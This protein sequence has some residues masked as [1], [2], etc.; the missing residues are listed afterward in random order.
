METEEQMRSEVWAEYL[1]AV[2]GDGE[3]REQW[4]SR[5][6]TYDKA[7]MRFDMKKKGEPGENGYPV[8]IA[9]H[10]G[11]SGKTPD[12]NDSQ[13]RHM[14]IY[15]FDSIRNGIYINPRG[16][17]DTWDTHFNRESYPLYDRMIENLIAYENADP[18][19][20]YLMGFSAGGDGVYGI[21]PRMADR[22]AAV[23]MSA[24]H[25]NG[26]R[27]ENLYRLPIGLQVGELDEAY[28]R[29]RVTPEYG[30]Y[31]DQLEKRYGGFEHQVYVHLDK[32]HNFMDHNP[33]RT[34][35]R[36]MA[37]PCAWLDS[38][39]RTET[40]ADTNAVSFLEKH[41]R[42]PLPDSLL[43]N[44]S[45]RATLREDK[46]FYWLSMEPEK[47]WR[48]R[49]WASIDR[50]SNRIKVD[51][52]AHGRLTV[53]LNGTMVDFDRPVILQVG[54]EQSEHILTPDRSLIQETTWQR[55]DVSY[56]FS[57]KLEAVL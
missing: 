41:V 31:L 12:R 28:H 40:L 22:F 3:R 38:G 27:L 53:Y 18:D 32:P 48:G 13:W 14:G 6:L 2:R 55:G 33:L 54:R 39:D 26:I 34:P 10:G 23:H 15:Y 49:V 44:V 36:V 52:T 50:E 20:I 57:A 21:A 42:E 47:Q 7:V 45:V 11:G 25:P 4:E 35:E 24:G 46:P 9:L 51:G 43:W 16:V 29:N 8:Y 1:A 30:R 56:Q 17:R 19:R 37:D 5:R